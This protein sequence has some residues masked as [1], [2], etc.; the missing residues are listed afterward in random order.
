MRR[1]AG[2]MRPRS[3]PARRAPATLGGRPDRAAPPSGFADRAPPLRP[4][5]VPRLRRA[6][7]CRARA[8]PA[9]CRQGQH[10]CGRGWRCGRRRRRSTLVRQDSRSIRSRADQ[11][12]RGGHSGTQKLE[13]DPDAS[14][15]DHVQDMAAQVWIAIRAMGRAHRGHWKGMGLGRHMWGR[16][17]SIALPVRMCA[18]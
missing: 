12:V 16:Y 14:T 11:A 2:P 10:G 1:W 15:L 5:G 3:R 18:S 4:L 9:G 7:R 6:K 17:V 8:R 13:V